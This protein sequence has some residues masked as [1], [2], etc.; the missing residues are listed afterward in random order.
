MKR[1]QVVKQRSVVMKG[2]AMI[3][4]SPLC[5]F[6][7][8]GDFVRVWPETARAL[9]GDPVEAPLADIA[10]SL[11]VKAPVV[12]IGPDGIRWRGAGLAR[13]QPSTWKHVTAAL[14]RLIVALRGRQDEDRPAVVCERRAS[15]EKVAMPAQRGGRIVA[16]RGYALAAVERQETDYAERHAETTGDT[17]DHSGLSKPLRLS[18]D[19]AGDWRPPE[20]H[21]GSRLRPRRSARKK[22]TPPSGPEAQGPLFT[23]LP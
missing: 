20:A 13:S 17:E 16:D 22:R 23:G 12:S 6:G 5:Q 2:G 14:K 11:G 8:G 18:P 19:D 21:K 4:N 15:L 3:P 1:Q 9:A 10:R 7:P